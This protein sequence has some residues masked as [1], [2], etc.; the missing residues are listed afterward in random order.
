[1]EDRH[2]GY[3]TKLGEKKKKKNLGHRHRLHPLKTTKL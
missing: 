2:L 1:M 3:I